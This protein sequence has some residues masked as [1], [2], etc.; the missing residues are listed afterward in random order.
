MNGPDPDT[1]HPMEGFPQVCFSVGRCRAF[2]RLRE[3]RLISFTGQ[4][5]P[6]KTTDRDRPRSLIKS[7]FSEALHSGP[8]AWTTAYGKN[9]GFLPSTRPHTRTPGKSP[10]INL[11]APE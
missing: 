9:R 3:G 1:K 7:S 4:Q 6:S 2:E 5:V 8:H 11:R 10:H